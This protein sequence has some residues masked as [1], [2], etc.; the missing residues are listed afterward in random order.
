MKL[1]KSM[2]YATRVLIVLGRGNTAKMPDLA[3]KLG[4]PYN[5]LVKIVQNLNRAGFLQTQTGR[6]GGIRLAKSPA[7]ISLKD[8]LWATEGPV[9]LSECLSGGRDTC[10]LNGHCKLK[11]TFN[12]LQGQIDRLFD[13]VKLAQVM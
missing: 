6:N 4:I 13:E 1:T 3:E 12:A 9:L 2:D 7:D 5:H 11:E 8:I 10:I